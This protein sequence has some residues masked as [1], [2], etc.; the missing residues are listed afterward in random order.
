MFSSYLER[1]ISISC[2]LEISFSRTLHN[3]KLAKIPGVNP[4]RFNNL[5]DYIEYTNW[6]RS[7]GIKCPILFLQHTYDAQ[8]ESV[9]KVRPSPTDLQGGLSSDAPI[10]QSSKKVTKL[11]DAARNDPP[12]NK[13]SYPGFDPQNQYVGLT[14]PLDKLFHENQ[15][16]KS[17]NP[18]D[19]NWGGG[20]Y[21]QALIDKGYYKEDEVFKITTSSG[22][23]SWQKPLQSYNRNIS[24]QPNSTDAPS[25]AGTT[26]THGYYGMDPQ[27]QSTSS[28]EP[29]YDSQSSSSSKPTSS[30]QSIP[31]SDSHAGV[32]QTHSYYG[33]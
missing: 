29:Q 13:N 6:Q 1:Y 19:P 4:I 2:A 26:H 18:M 20:N 24:Q 14:T 32:T 8:G 21:T 12:Y 10:D 9:Y 17:P 27:S 28:M 7:Q 3:S 33:N 11:V 5:E 22:V 31:N 25:H 23:Q 30:T 16:D 15:Q